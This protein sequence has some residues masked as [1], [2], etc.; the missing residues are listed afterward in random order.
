LAGSTVR[1]LQPNQNKALLLRR[2][3]PTRN[4]CY[5][6]APGPRD[7]SRPQPSAITQLNIQQKVNTLKGLEADN[8]KRTT[9]NDAAR[10]ASEAAKE[11]ASSQMRMGEMVVASDREIAQARLEINHASVQQRLDSE[12][13]FSNRELAVQLAGNQAQIA[14]LDK[15]SKD[16]PNQ[17]KAL[18]DKAVELQQ[19]HDSQV[20]TMTVQSQAK[21]AAQSL[22]D[23]QESEREKIGA[24][25]Q[26]SAGRLAAIDAAI[27]EE[28]EHNLQAED[29]YR[30]LLT[31]HVETVR[32]MAQQEM[33][34]KRQAIE[35]ATKVDEQSVQSQFRIAQ[36]QLA[37]RG[38][39]IAQQETLA[40]DQENRI[41]QIQ[42]SGLQ[43]ELQALRQSGAAK[44][45]EVQHI[46][47]QI[48]TLTQTQENRIAEI[49]SQA[50][51]QRTQE[52]N[53]AMATMENSAARSLLSMLSGQRS[54]ASV[55]SGLASSL[56]ES[57]VT[58]AIERMNHQKAEKLSNAET[59][60][61]NTYAE[62]SGW[63]VVGPVLAPVAAS[64]A[65]AAVMAFERG[66]VVPG[67]GRG[68]VVPA[69]L[70]P[71]EGVVPGG[72]MDGLTKMA[73]DGGFRGQ[74]VT[75]VHVRPTYNVQAIDGKGMGDALEK[76]NDVL[77]K[78]FVKAVR[79]MNR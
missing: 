20:A 11:A 34:A 77:Q 38:G 35:A 19:Q 53:R 58:A 13:E 41:F 49:E 16:Y 60:A 50:D 74:S 25:Q 51:N 8:A 23:M 2:S 15:F 61:S 10:Q 46:Q 42:Q 7:S 65:F 27:K 78:H 69:M 18:N 63:P 29:G 32:E 62:V 3:E 72:V 47:Q 22:R 17:L 52:F 30:G 66:G 71:G 44:V 75:H 1:L 39:T 70:T 79:R 24:T 28:A 54:F 5:R 6:A 33:Q 12:I 55:M 64:A 57:L 48:Q 9:G 40:L 43:K 56:T 59:A 26:G 14:A 68:D 36:E 4:S 76:H 73:R 21:Q 67:V 45:A 37:A 31:Q